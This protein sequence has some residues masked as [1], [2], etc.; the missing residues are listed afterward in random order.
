MREKRKRGPEKIYDR[1]A[2]YSQTP[3]PP[4]W[5]P[6]PIVGFLRPALLLA[7]FEF[8]A[9]FRRVLRKGMFALQIGLPEYKPDRERG[10]P[11][12]R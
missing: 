10:P 4:Q 12:T 3:S 1:L 6:L 7:S 11:N 2:R 8:L 9:G 5:L